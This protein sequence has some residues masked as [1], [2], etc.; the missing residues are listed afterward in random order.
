[1]HVSVFIAI[2]V[3][4]YQG[5]IEKSYFLLWQ[6]WLVAYLYFPW[7][8][9]PKFW[10]QVQRTGTEMGRETYRVSPVGEGD[11]ERNPIPQQLIRLQDKTLT[12][13]YTHLGALAGARE[14]AAG[15]ESQNNQGCLHKQ[16][17]EKT[18]TESTGKWKTATMNEIGK[19]WSKRAR[20]WRRMEKNV[21]W[22][23]SLDLWD[24]RADFG[25]A[26]SH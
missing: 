14:W 1:M 13:T 4:L 20:R 17:P 7:I 23:K 16:K 21:D 3:L 8:S 11:R 19:N 6:T 24:T 5:F 22:R 10:P 12:H 25:S 2:T 18:I 15:W 9:H 26:L